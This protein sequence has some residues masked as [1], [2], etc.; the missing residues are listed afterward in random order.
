MTYQASL[1]ELAG[2]TAN[3]KEIRLAGIKKRFFKEETLC[4]IG[5]G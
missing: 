1:R 4:R 2:K 5:I 3:S